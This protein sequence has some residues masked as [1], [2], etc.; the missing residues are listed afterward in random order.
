LGVF[1]GRA[2]ASAPTD[3][4]APDVSNI[5]NTTRDSPTIN[6]RRRQADS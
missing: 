6:V 2:P 3:A 1:D 5:G 4:F